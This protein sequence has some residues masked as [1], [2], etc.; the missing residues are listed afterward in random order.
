MVT[1]KSG[2]REQ[3]CTGSAAIYSGRRDPEWEVP[4]EAARRLRELWDSLEPARRAAP[5]APALGYRGCTLNC[6]L[7]GRWFALSGVV[8][9]DKEHRRDADRSFERTLL[10]TAPKGSLP[11]WV[12]D[13]LK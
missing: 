12:F 6:P 4:D 10:Q 1:S 5:N 2:E 8:S 9:K 13:Q 7:H 11:D 3:P